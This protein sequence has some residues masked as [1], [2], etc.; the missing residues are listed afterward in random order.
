MIIPLLFAFVYLLLNVPV[1]FRLALGFSGGDMDAMAEASLL[2]IGWRI[3]LQT[4]RNRDSVIPTWQNRY[5][6]RRSQ[7]SEKQI[8]RNLKFIRKLAFHARYSLLRVFALVG[9]GDAAA[10]TALAAGAVLAFLRGFCARYGLPVDNVRVIPHF[11]KVTFSL[12]TECIATLCV[13]DIIFAAFHKPKK[14]KRNE[15]R[16][17]I[18]IRSKV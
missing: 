13:G 15:G 4:E 10:E 17:W 16:Q 12:E 5:E 7:R 18:S 11:S 9:C 8:H 2:G 14:Q 1:H 6:I 3:D